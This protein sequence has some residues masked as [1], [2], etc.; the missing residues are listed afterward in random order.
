MNANGY[1]A[2]HSTDASERER[3][4]L[5]ARAADP[6][7]TTRLTSLGVGPGWRCLDVGAGAGS[8]ALWLAD[9]VGPTGRVT[10]TDLNPRFL[11]GFVS[12]NLEVRRHDIL[13]D[14]LELAHY[15]LV[16]C[17]AVLMH[18]PDPWRALR[19]MAAAVRPGGWLLVEELDFGSFAACDPGHPRAAT[20]GRITKALHAAVQA[21]GIIDLAFARRLPA[22]TRESGL[23]DAEHDAVTFID[24]GGGPVARNCHLRQ[25]LVRDALLSS[26]VLGEADLD[27]L[28]EAYE[29]PSFWFVGFTDVGAWGRRLR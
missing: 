22:L 23:L 12:P 27:E 29:D 19:R 14:D 6:I 9:H 1:F 2:K 13:T 20:F 26:G 21:G 4:S 7:T 18:L 24:R 28:R 25:E 5:L 10:A 11:A 8:V 3:L 17:R 16:H 15:D